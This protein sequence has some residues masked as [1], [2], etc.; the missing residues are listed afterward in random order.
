MAATAVVALV[1]VAA[2]PVAVWAAV[3]VVW[4]AVVA[5]WWQCGAPIRLL[6]GVRLT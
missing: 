1:P 3:P 2:V 5:V 4:A 6:V